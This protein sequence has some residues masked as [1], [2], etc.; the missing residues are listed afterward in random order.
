VAAAM[1]ELQQKVLTL[2]VEVLDAKNMHEKIQ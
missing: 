2:A 1:D